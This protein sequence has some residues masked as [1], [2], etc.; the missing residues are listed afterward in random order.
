[1]KFFD[2]FSSPERSADQ[3]THEWAEFNLPAD[4]QSAQ[5]RLDHVDLEGERLWLTPLDIYR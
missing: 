2:A 1:M 5:T 3:A 4:F